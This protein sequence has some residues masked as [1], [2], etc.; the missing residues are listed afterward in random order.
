MWVS[1]VLV[2]RMVGRLKSSPLIICITLVVRIAGRLKS[3]ILIDWI[4]TTHD[5]H[6][7]MYL[8]CTWVLIV[9]CTAASRIL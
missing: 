9:F 8:D 6:Y 3:S 1:I 7:M 2:V 5:S 4:R